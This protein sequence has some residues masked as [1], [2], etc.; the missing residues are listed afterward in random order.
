MQHLS[1][2]PAAEAMRLVHRYVEAWTDAARS[3]PQAHR[4]AN[5]GRRA[6]NRYLKGIRR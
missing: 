4:R 5:A 2:L 1:G 3:E 6:A